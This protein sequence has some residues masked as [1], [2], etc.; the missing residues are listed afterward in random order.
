M[1]QR[2]VCRESEAE[3]PTK[4]EGI[5]NVRFISYADNGFS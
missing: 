1:K 4:A 3:R 5:K 2:Q